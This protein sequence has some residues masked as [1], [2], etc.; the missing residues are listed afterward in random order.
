MSKKYDESAV[1]TLNA[2]EFKYNTNMKKKK[3]PVEEMNFLHFLADIKEITLGGT[4]SGIMYN[5]LVKVIITL[6]GLDSYTTWCFHKYGWPKITLK[7][8]RGETSH[9]TSSLKDMMLYD[10]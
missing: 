1:K 8:L 3:F 5:F 4:A 9:N 6:Q 2:L 10:M 7:T